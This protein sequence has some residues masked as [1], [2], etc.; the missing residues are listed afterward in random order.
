[1][2]KT[3]AVIHGEANTSPD[4]PAPFKNGDMN[5]SYAHFA[6]LGERYGVN[7][8]ISSPPLV[9]QEDAL[10][11]PGTREARGWT[12]DFDSSA[13]K[14]ITACPHLF[15]DRFRYENASEQEKDLRGL[16]GEE[17]C[18]VLHRDLEALCKDKYL[19][20]CEFPQYVLPTFLVTGRVPYETILAELTRHLHPDLSLAHCVAKN[21]YG[22]G[23]EGISRDAPAGAVV[24]Q[25][26]VGGSVVDTSDRLVQPY[27]DT[28]SGIPELGITRRHDLR[29]VIVNGKPV[30]A[31]AR[32]LHEQHQGQEMF[33]PKS[34]TAETIPLPVDSIPARFLDVASALDAHLAQRIGQTRIYSVDMGQG[35]SGRPW[36]FELN[37]RPQQ[38]WLS[39][40]QYSQGDN[41][42]L[43]AC[44]KQ[45]QAAIVEALAE[46]M[47]ES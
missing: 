36:V 18:T 44:R 39:R 46:Q 9:S 19:T 8:M 13:W 26:M 31:E 28:A 25:K 35:A 38:T 43:I 37:S 30:V 22:S 33:F 47:Y 10:K 6:Q 4:A 32:V 14:A 42:A 27:L 11:H 21:R 40:S 1:M 29:L 5:T 12:Y 16:L 20:W 24:S 34:H 7:I 23:G 17:G 3:I 2:T 41:E 45:Q 15:Y